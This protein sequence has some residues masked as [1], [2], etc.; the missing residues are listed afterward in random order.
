VFLCLILACS[1]GRQQDSYPPPPQRRD[2]SGPD[3]K[4]V[5]SYV[6]MGEPQVGRYVVSGIL[7]PGSPEGR[8]WTSERPEL[9]FA[10]DQTA[11]LK[12]EMNL[13]VPV[14]TLRD[15]GP[16]TITFFVNGKQLG[17]LY[18]PEPG[19]FHYEAP[20]PEGWLHVG[21]DNRVAASVDKYWVASLDGQRLGFIL[22]DVGFVPR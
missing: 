10:L 13:A 17:K 15:T 20:V 11:D 14:V 4:P 1:C 12:L 21:A 8:S 7:A 18:C 6:G 5:A 19:T 2:F 22:T 3:P 16:I 9:R